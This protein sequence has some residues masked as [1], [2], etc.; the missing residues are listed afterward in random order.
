[1][2]MVQVGDYITTT[3]FCYGVVLK[4]NLRGVVIR[5]DNFADIEI[6]VKHEDILDTISGSRVAPNSANHS[7]NEPAR[8]LRGNAPPPSF[9]DGALSESDSNGASIRIEA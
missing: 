7:A 3:K 6:F 5:L 1:M 2:T 9:A 4:R 8:S